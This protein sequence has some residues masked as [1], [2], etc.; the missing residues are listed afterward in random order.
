[1]IVIY[2]QDNTIIR[3]DADSAR[4]DLVRLYGEKLGSEAY[5]AVKNGRLGAVYRNYGG[6]LVKVIS[7]KDAAHIKEKE[8]RGLPV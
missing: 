7:S 5:E 6:P 4:G 1:M 3:E 2:T 8:T